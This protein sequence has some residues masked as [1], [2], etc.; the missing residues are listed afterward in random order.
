MSQYT[1]RI[2]SKDDVGAIND[3]FTA[4]FQLQPK[5]NFIRWKYFSNPAG[6]ALVAGAFYKGQLVGSGAMIP[7]MMSVFSQ[8]EVVFKFTDLMTHPEHQRKGLSKNINALLK[9]EGKKI[10][11]SFIYTLCSNVST[12]S[13]VSNGWVFMSKV[14][15][16]FKPVSLLRISHLL[17]KRSNMSFSIHH[18]ID[19]H[20]DDYPFQNMQDRIHLM[21]SPA[22]LKWRTA[23][24]NFSY[25][26][27]CSRDKHNKINGYLLFSTSG[28]KLLSIIDL[29]AASNNRKGIAKG[30]VHHAEAIAIQEGYR[31]VTA[32]ATEGTAFYAFMKSCNYLMNP[33]GKGPLKAILDFDVYNFKASDTSITDCSNWEILGLNYDDV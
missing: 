23:N 15:N 10:N 7:E 17:K 12:K 28:N 16:F 1:Y 6:D 24:P 3:L 27:I 29:E 9:E 30:L 33:F 25:R 11:I 31:G 22:F 18:S 8:Q 13:F 32:L 14:F 5:D 4:A 19:H 26:L 20:L 21:K 2:L